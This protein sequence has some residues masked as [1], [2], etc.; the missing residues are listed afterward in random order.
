MLRAS[1]KA[2]VFVHLFQKVADSKDSVFGRTPQSAKNFIHESVFLRV[3]KEFCSVAAGNFAQYSM[4]KKSKLQIEN[5]FFNLLFSK[6]KA[7]SENKRYVLFRKTS[8]WEIFLLSVLLNIKTIRFVSTLP[9]QS[10]V[11]T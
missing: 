2:K 7:P 10:N 6:K 8:Q 1:T 9:Q 4:G 11:L 5:L 3:K